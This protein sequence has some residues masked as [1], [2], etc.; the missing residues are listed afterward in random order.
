MGDQWEAIPNRELLQVQMPEA[1]PASI[2]CSLT[3]H[4]LPASLTG[5]I[6]VSSHHWK[7]RS[8][9]DEL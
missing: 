8:I 3:C 4:S 9:I 1:G 2:F 7:L 6:V 5:G